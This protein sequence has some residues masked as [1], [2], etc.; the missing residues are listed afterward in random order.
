MNITEKEKCSRELS[1][2]RSPFVLHAELSEYLQ[3]H[4]MIKGKKI[5]ISEDWYPNGK[6]STPW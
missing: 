3:A 2:E 5:L 4:L 6:N 1:R